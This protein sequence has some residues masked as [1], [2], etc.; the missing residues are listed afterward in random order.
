M[1]EENFDAV[2][3]INKTLKKTDDQQNKEV[4]FKCNHHISRYLTSPFV[5]GCCIIAGFK[6]TIVRT[7][8]ELCFRRNESKC[9]GFNATYYE[10]RPSELILFVRLRLWNPKQIHT[11]FYF[12]TSTESTSWSMPTES[13]NGRNSK[14]HL[15]SSQRNKR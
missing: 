15:S 2:D 4:H 1:S 12:G 5:L 6:V 9:F 14:R 7:T 10:W 3:W 11:Y 13:K 8:S